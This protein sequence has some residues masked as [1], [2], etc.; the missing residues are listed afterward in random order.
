MPKEEKL[1][2]TAA[3]V[4]AANDGGEDQEVLSL[5]QIRDKVRAFRRAGE[6]GDVRLGERIDALQADLIN[7]MQILDMHT[8]R[9][10]AIEAKIAGGGSG[11]PGEFPAAVMDL[12]TLKQFVRAQFGEA[13]LTAQMDGAAKKL[14]C[15]EIRNGLAIR[16][17]ATIRR[18]NDD[19][20]GNG[21]H[22]G[23]TK[24]SDAI[25][26]VPEATVVD[27]CSGSDAAG[28]LDQDLTWRREPINPW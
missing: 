7:T 4:A 10:T 15:A 1:K 11:D 21:Y 27:F 24:H 13:F 19:P 2:P 17:P 23:E 26:Y 8:D 16:Y 14:A 5:K 12:A 3:E 28:V 25:W 20:I 6:L 9:L 18:L 22:A